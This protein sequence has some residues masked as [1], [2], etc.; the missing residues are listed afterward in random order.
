M[1]RNIVGSL[2]FAGLATIVAAFVLF[3]P[4]LALAPAQAAPAAGDSATRGRLPSVAVHFADLDVSREAGVSVLYRRIQNAAEQVCESAKR[5][6]TR[7]PSLEWL[8]CKSLAVTDAVRTLDQPL[9]SDYHQRKI[10]AAASSR[11]VLSQ[12][13]H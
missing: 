13:V 10:G 7:I 5:V 11:T 2:S 3:S 12:R 9:L 1:C 4:F 8:K 6:D